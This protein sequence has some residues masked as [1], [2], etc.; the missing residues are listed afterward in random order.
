MSSA[1]DRAGFLIVSTAMQQCLV[2][3]NVNDLDAT[4]N[5]EAS[6]R[7]LTM[8]EIERLFLTLA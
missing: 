6:P 1:L 8:E 5:G 7:K 4:K 3:D 2:A